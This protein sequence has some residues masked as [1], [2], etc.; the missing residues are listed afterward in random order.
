MKQEA[1]DAMVI[2]QLQ[3]DIAKFKSTGRLPG[4]RYDETRTIQTRRPKEDRLNG[5]WPGLSPA[6]LYIAEK[7]TSGSEKAQLF[8]ERETE[9]CASLTDEEKAVY[10]KHVKNG[11]SQGMTANVL[12]LSQPRVSRIKRSLREKIKRFFLR[13]SAGVV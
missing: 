10:D 1:Y 5:G 9:I 8:A 6:F 4:D 11:L 3:K 12:G 2:R 7:D 13:A